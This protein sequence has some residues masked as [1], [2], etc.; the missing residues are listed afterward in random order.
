MAII[1]AH[2][3]PAH[4]AQTYLRPRERS[5][6]QQLG[7]TGFVISHHGESGHER[8]EEGIHKEPAHRERT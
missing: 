2:E 8:S 3:T 6:L 5:T 1:I 7:E 4:F